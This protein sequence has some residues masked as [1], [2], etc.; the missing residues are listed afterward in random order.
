LS[1]LRPSCFPPTSPMRKNRRQ[2][3]ASLPIFAH[4]RSLSYHGRGFLDI[5]PPKDDAIEEAD[6][7]HSRQPSRNTSHSLTPESFKDADIMKSLE[8]GP[9][10]WFKA[11][12]LCTLIL[13]RS[14]RSTCSSVLKPPPYHAITHET[15]SHASTPTHPRVPPFPLF[16][17]RLFLYL[18]QL[19]RR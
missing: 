2:G 4:D 18:S 6:M 14:S 13:L 12:I 19:L 11:N 1:I 5:V 8:D 16:H 9:F 17:L 15:L 7:A 3:A 10:R